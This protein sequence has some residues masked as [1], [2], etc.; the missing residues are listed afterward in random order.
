MCHPL[1][2]PLLRSEVLN[3][4]IA[5]AKSSALLLL[6]SDAPAPKELT[7]NTS[8]LQMGELGMDAR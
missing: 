1:S 4:L 7:W 8:L 6:K 2:A 3:G 5:S